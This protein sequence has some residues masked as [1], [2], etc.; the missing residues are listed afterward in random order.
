MEEYQY[1]YID[2]IFEFK[3]K[4]FVP[5]LLWNITLTMYR[6]ITFVYVTKYYFNCV[7]SVNLFMLL[8]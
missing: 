1:L 2:A 6:C 8:V 7:R 3:D 4:N 5:I